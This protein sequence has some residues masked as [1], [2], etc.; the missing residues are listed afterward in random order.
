MTN[1]KNPR[2]SASICGSFLCTNIRNLVVFY[3]VFFKKELLGFCFSPPSPKAEA[4]KR[5]AEAKN[6]S[7][8]PQE[9][10]FDVWLRP[11]AKPEA[12]LGFF[13]LSRATPCN[14][15][16]LEYF[17]FSGSA[18]GAGT[19]GTRHAERSTSWFI[20]EYLPVSLIYLVRIYFL[21]LGVFRQDSETHH[22]SY[23]LMVDLEGW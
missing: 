11:R 8:D 17:S 2:L 16:F 23:V 1:I 22:F 19:L 20:M 10:I 9:P 5:K 3:A 4:V 6:N 18:F 14:G 12:A 7:P 21:R 15:D 13:V